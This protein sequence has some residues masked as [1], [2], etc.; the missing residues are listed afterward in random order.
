M[1]C[2]VRHGETHS[3]EVGHEKLRGW[4]PVPLSLA[5][6]AGTKETAELLD[7]IES[8]ARIMCG[9]LVRVIQSAAEIAQVLQMELEPDEN[10]NDWN[11][12]DF[13]GEPVQETLDDLH[14][15]IRQPTKAVPGGESF[16]AFMDRIV[17][18]LTDAVES[19]D[20]NI[21]VSSGRI[22]TL[23][24]ALS[25]NGG[26]TPDQAILLGKPPIDPSGILILDRDWEITFSTR[27]SEESKGLS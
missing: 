4:L 27:K 21:V 24:K 5:G 25:A 22:S 9:T 12:G 3:N 1:I 15:H 13:A 26:K 17:P 18:V 19:K 10:L 2:F 23:L 20:I 6:M 7:E 16:Q 8:P 11:T 14:S